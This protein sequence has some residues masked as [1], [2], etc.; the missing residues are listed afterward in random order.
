M[1]HYLGSI[2]LAVA[3][4]RDGHRAGL[5]AVSSCLGKR[6]HIGVACQQVCKVVERCHRLAINT[7]KTVSFPEPHLI[8]R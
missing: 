3:G 4:K 8:G 7:R 1:E 2:L 5:D 6:Q